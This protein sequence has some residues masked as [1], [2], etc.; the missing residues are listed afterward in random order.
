MSVSSIVS[1]GIA[2]PSL[3]LTSTSAPTN[4]TAGNFWHGLV[5]F[6]EGL[7]CADLRGKP[8]TVSFLFNSNISGN[9]SFSLRDGTTTQSYVTTFACV[10]N[11]PVK[12]S[13]PIPAIPLAATV[14]YTNATGLSVTIGCLNTANLQ[15]STL[16]A[17][18]AGNLLTA[19]TATNW[20][21]T[22]G[23]WI[24]VTELQL[25]EGSVATPFE[26]RPYGAE[27]A[28]CQRYYEVV[29]MLFKTTINNSLVNFRQVKRADPTLVITTTSGTGATLG[30]CLDAALGFYQAAANTVE[31]RATVTAS[32][33]L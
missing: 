21:A 11:T 32:S 12:V 1:G 28:L 33:E 9:I 18:Q 30:V 14:P 17:W 31:T 4:L 13:I 7:N 22:N 26:H 27:L 23:N 20:A 16:N 3:R 5:Q 29:G 25:E 24:D 10:A 15:T 19:N 2:K 6:I 8:V